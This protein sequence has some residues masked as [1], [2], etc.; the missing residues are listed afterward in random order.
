MTT[1]FF[2]RQDSARSQTTRLLFLFG[3]AVLVIVIALSVFGFLVGNMINEGSSGRQGLRAPAGNVVSPWLVSAMFG[4]GSLIVIALG[5]LYQISML[6]FG[7]GTRVAESVGGRQLAHHTSDPLERRLLN[8]VEEM[9]IASGTPVPPVYLMDETGINAF[10]A[11][12]LPGDAVVGVTRGAIENLSRDELQGVIAHE[13]SHIFNGDMRTNI[14]LIGVLHG[15]LVLSLIGQMLL[16]SLRFMNTGS[17][18]KNSGAIIVVLLVLGIVLIVLGSL[19]SLLGGLIKAAVSRQREYLADASAVQFTRNPLGIAGALKRI[20]GAIYGSK[21]QHP[22]AAMA[23]HMYFAQ[24]VFEGLSG[25]M[26]THPPLPKRIAAIDPS[27][28]GSFFATAAESSLRAGQAF[29]GT[30]SGVNEHDEIGLSQASAGAMAGLAPTSKMQE[31]DPPQKVAGRSSQT[32]PAKPEHPSRSFSVPEMMAATDN[33]GAPQD[34]HRDYA[35]RLLEQMDPV[36]LQAAHEP[37]SARA[38][39]MALLIDADPVLANAQLALLQK[40][41]P[42]D[43]FNAVFTLVPHVKAVPSAARLPLVDMSLPMLRMMSLPQY[44]AFIPAFQALVQADQR[45]SVFEW[46]LSQ[47]LFRHLHS[48][49][50]AR[51]VV[52][53]QYHS[54]AGLKPE[55]SLLLSTLARTGNSEPE[56]ARAFAAGGSQLP[57]IELAMVPAELCTFAE[58]EKVIHRLA[59]ATAKLRRQVLLACAACVSSDNV[60]KIREVELVRGIADLLDCP[61]PPLVGRQE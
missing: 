52:G 29:S 5:S 21:V 2:E 15:I 46:T 47:V 40:M 32:Q 28:D 16:R 36:L 48:H 44:Q 3:L 17:D 38:L 31:L 30:T 35:N 59:Q 7:G 43:L 34:E 20:G 50:V 25:L 45:L 58:L 41:V 1:Q 8:V 18:N 4:G 24:G 14:R 23:S 6:R 42:V 39:V 22:N 12:Y 49:F 26:A 27:W 33:V 53:T 54:L 51:P 13:F 10:A 56:A 60:V 37:Y 9:A 57:G 55:V 11:G 61:M 19:G